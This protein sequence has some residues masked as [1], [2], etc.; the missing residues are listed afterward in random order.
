M[1]KVISKDGTEIAYESVGKGP[2]LI[3]V[4]GALCYRSF[5]PMTELAKLVAPHFTV[6]TYDRRGRGDSGNEKPFAVEREVED[7]DALIKEAGGS[8]FVFGTSS[9]GCLALEAA[10]KLGS[11]VKKLA[12]YEAP[13]NSEKTALQAWKE[14]RKNLADL[15]AVDRCGDAAALFMQ[16]VGTPADQVEGMR[17]APVWPMFEA[18]APTL[19][20]DAAAM[21]EDRSA[22]VKRAGNITVPALVMDG[23]ANLA[24]IPFMHESATALARAIPHAQHRTLEGQRHDVDLK[25]LAPVLIEFFTK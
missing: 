10:I 8:A 6:Y 1:N 5:G 25:I 21:G 22:P 2:A 4:D 7:I 9:G 13:Y 24:V 3:L 14:Y 23:G 18:V 16:F 11:K 15:L 17:H 20:Y 12:I 19:A